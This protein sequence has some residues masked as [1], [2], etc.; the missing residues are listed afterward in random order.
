MPDRRPS[1]RLPDDPRMLRAENLARTVADLGTDPMA[2]RDFLARMAFI[3]AFEAKAWELSRTNPPQILG[4]IVAL[5]AFCGGLGWLVS[6]TLGIDPLSAYLATSPGGMDSVAIIAAAS[7]NVDISFIM[8]L[9]TLRFLL[10][11]L[12]GPGLARLVARAVRA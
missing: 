3:R 7:H 9:Q 8:A 5:V 4:S 6:S 2:R 1:S 12:L 11:L 10:V